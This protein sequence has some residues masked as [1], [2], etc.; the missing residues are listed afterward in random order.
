M[1]RP[2]RDYSLTP[3]ERFMG[4]VFKTE[5]CWLWRGTVKAHGYGVIRIDNTYWRAHRLSWTLFNGAI[6]D[7][8]AVCHRCD[9]PRCVNPEHLFLGTQADNMRDMQSKGRKASANVNPAKG[10]AHG[11]AKLTAAQVSDIRHANEH[12][13]TQSQLAAIYGVTQSTI[14]AIIRGVNWK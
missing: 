1:S 4:R 14:S 10:E 8:K 2:P 5:T 11:R 7:G 6:P 9:N 12:G 3:T 13:A